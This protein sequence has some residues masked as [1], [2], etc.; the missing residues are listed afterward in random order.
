LCPFTVYAPVTLL[1]GG[2]TKF[3]GGPLAISAIYN[4]NSFSTLHDGSPKESSLTGCWL[5]PNVQKESGWYI[6][7][8]RFYRLCLLLLKFILDFQCFMQIAIALIHY[9]YLAATSNSP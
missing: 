2:F 7:T 5:T 1:A 4:N 9:Q 6:T 8:T 3:Y